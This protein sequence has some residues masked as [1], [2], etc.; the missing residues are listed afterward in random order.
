MPGPDRRRPAGE[1]GRLPA[2][3]RRPRRPRRGRAPAPAS[4]AGARRTRLA[5]GGACAGGA[6]ARPAPRRRPPLRRPGPA[7]LRPPRP[8]GGGPRRSARR[9]GRA[10]DAPRRPP[11][12]RR[13]AHLHPHRRAHRCDRPR[14]ARQRRAPAALGGR[15]AAAVRRSR[16]RGP[17]RR[18]DRGQLRLLARRAGLRVPARDLGRR[19]SAGPPRPPDRRGPGLALPGRGACPCPRPVRVR[20][21]AD[22]PAELRAIFPHGQRR[23]RLRSVPG[24]PLP[25]ARLG[26]ELGGLLRPRHHLGLARDRHDGV[27]AL[28]LGGARRAARHRRRLRARAP[29]GGDPVSLR[30]LRPPPRRAVRDRDPLPR[31]AGDP[32][33]RRGDGPVARHGGGARE[34]GLGLGQRQ[35]AGGAADRARPRSDRAAAG[36]DAPPRRRDHR[37]SASP[38]PARRRFRHHRGPARRAGPGRERDDGGPH[39]HLLGQGRHRRPRHSQ[40]RHPRARDAHLHPQGL[41]PDRRPPRR[42]LQPRHAAGRGS[43]G[44]RHVVQGG[45]LGRIPGGNRGRR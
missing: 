45:L 11:P 37:L 7:A 25:G 24:H 3:G 13:R 2:G 4:A 21:G 23:G 8:A 29:R 5:G 34:P 17:A 15:D 41:R 33:G 40:G 39:G 12:P 22:R 35:P 20:A 16:G 1:E 32:R 30:P 26:G 9:L 14:G 6:A 10:A 28:R 19:G 38:Q 43:G 44:L 36:A 31:Q 42:P 27:R 18:R